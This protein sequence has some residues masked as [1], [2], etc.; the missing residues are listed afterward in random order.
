MVSVENRATTR[1][2]ELSL[3][4][5]QMLTMP[6]PRAILGCIA[7]VDSDVFPT[8]ARSLIGKKRCELSPS[9]IRDAL[10]K[11]MIMDHPIDAQI[12]DGYDTKAIDNA[13]AILVGKV[14][15]SVSYTLVDAGNHLPLFRSSRSPLLLFRQLPLCFTQHLLVFAKEMGIVNILPGRQSSK[16]G[17]T[18]INAHGLGGFRE[19]LVFNFTSKSHKP[20]ASACAPNAAGLNPT[21]KRSVDDSLHRADLRQDDSIGIDRISTLGI[22]ETIIPASTTKSRIARLLPSLY[23]PEESLE[24]E[25]N[26]HSHILQYLAMNICKGRALLFQC[27]EQVNLVIH[28]ERFFAFFPG[29]FSLLQKVVVEPTALVQSVLQSSD[30]ACRR[31]ESIAKGYLVHKYVIAQLKK[32]VKPYRAS[33]SVSPALKSGVLDG[34][35]L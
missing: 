19:R 13:P 2:L 10:S 3:G 26:P 15:P 14:Y 31:I 6:T 9:C 20:L 25:V 17:Q 8:G 23:S 33:S 32:G 7:W 24:S 35:I 5:S 18:N 28:T 12:F 1:A 30:L 22:G 21:F 4:E 16:M 29:C 27:E 11:A 34:D